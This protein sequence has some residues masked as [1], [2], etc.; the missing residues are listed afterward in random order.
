MPAGVQRGSSR[1]KYSA[2]GAEQREQLL[3]EFEKSRISAAKFAADHGINPKTFQGWVKTR[4]KKGRPDTELIVPGGK[5]IRVRKWMKVEKALVEYCNLRRSRV[6]I[7]KCGLPYAI[8]GEKARAWK[9]TL[10]PSSDEPFTA[11]DGWISA[12]LKHGGLIGV[13]LSG[14]AEEM[15]V[16]EAEALMKE[17][18]ERVKRVCEEFGIGAEC[19]YNADQTGLYYRKLPNRIYVKKAER[20]TARGVKQMKDKDRV[21][22]MVCTSA[23]GKKL[24]LAMVGTAKTP[25]CFR[26]VDS[27]PMA[28]THQSK[29]WF[30]RTVTIW[31]INTVLVPNHRRIYG[32][33]PLL[34]ILDN[35][36]AHHGVSKDAYPSIVHIEFLP[37]NLT[38]KH[39]PADQG[40]IAAL[41]VGYKLHMLRKLLAICENPDEYQAAREAA[42]SAKRGCVGLEYAHK[43]HLL[44]AMQILNHIW[45]G[46]DNKYCKEPGIIN[47]W[48]KA[49]CLPLE[50]AEVSEEGSDVSRKYPK[51]SDDDLSSLCSAMG[52]LFKNSS[53]K[54]APALIDS[55]AADG[56]DCDLDV[57]TM[58]D[59]VHEWLFVEDNAAVKEAEVD[60]ALAE[61]EE[62]I[63]EKVSASQPEVRYPPASLV[64]LSMQPFAE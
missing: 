47:C 25:H 48:R 35:C 26:L 29:G 52:S 42:K 37:P 56:G 43:P 32:E 64:E 28:Y 17:F 4:K 51:L 46:S 14:E 22:I 10:Y 20:K 34:L 39:Q 54:E 2:S 7:D 45:E 5:R 41:K 44:D 61:F 55:M 3:D 49:E 18:R 63:L 15:D 27:V 53:A 1:G 62:K 57:E 36:P 11:S 59:V 19:I 31:W 13:S 12:T 40:M 24:P 50:L 9:E 8:L 30:D 23:T 58:E 38:S 33:V 21:T 6:T 60:E 16:A